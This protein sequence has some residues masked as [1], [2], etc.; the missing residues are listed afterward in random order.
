M[1]NSSSNQQQNRVVTTTACKKE[2]GTKNSSP[3]LAGQTVRI[4]RNLHSHVL[5]FCQVH[6][7]FK[8]HFIP[9][10]GR[11]VEERDRG[12]RGGGE[13]NAERVGTGNC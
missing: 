9:F 4:C 10:R 11:K 3:S 8:S 12:D 7:M 13:E 5:G 6:R 2:W 1:K